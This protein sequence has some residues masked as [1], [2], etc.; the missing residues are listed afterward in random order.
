MRLN[1][2]VFGIMATILSTSAFAENESMKVKILTGIEISENEEIPIILEGDYSFLDSNNKKV[3]LQNCISLQQ[4]LESIESLKSAKKKL[5]L[6][7]SIRIESGRE[8]FIKIY[9]I[10]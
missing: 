3:N 2:F 8:V 9:R 4:S 6:P 5:T 10:F 1:K 7:K